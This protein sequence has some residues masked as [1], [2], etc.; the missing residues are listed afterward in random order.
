MQTAQLEALQSMI[1]DLPHDY[2]KKL[3]D[4]RLK[5]ERLTRVIDYQINEEKR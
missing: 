1:P 5:Q 4:F 3:D 2:D